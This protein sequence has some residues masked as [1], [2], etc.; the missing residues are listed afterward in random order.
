MQKLFGII[1][2]VNANF[3]FGFGDGQDIEEFLNIGVSLGCFHYFHT[4]VC[5]QM[6]PGGGLCGTVN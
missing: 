5:S 6:T 1:A 3:F 4:K 2:I